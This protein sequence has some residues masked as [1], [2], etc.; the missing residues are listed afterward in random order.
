MGVEIQSKKIGTLILSLTQEMRTIGAS[1]YNFRASCNTFIAA[2]KCRDAAKIY[3]TSVV[4]PQFCFFVR[5]EHKF[6]PVSVLNIY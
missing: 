3:P 6:M 4:Y 1:C 2:S 5:D